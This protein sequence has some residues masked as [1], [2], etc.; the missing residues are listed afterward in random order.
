MYLVTT[1]DDKCAQIIYSNGNGWDWPVNIKLLHA[2]IDKSKYIDDVDRLDN[3]AKYILRNLSLHRPLNKSEF[4]TRS[5]LLKRLVE[6]GLP[7]VTINVSVNAIQNLCQNNDIN[8]LKLL[9][10]LP[11]KDIQQSSAVFQFAC[12]KFQFDIH[13]NGLHVPRGQTFHNLEMLES[14]D[15]FQDFFVANSPLSK[16]CY[17][18]RGMKTLDLKLEL[19]T[20]TF[21]TWNLNKALKYA[22]TPPPPFTVWLPSVLLVIKLH[23]NCPIITTRFPEEIVLPRY[24]DIHITNSCILTDVEISH[25]GYSTKINTLFVYFVDCLSSK[26]TRRTQLARQAV[27]F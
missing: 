9:P 13:D 11:D 12:E 21:A 5:D 27:S 3:I 15:K 26:R 8:N 14:L 6:L 17:V 19:N 20:V 7:F 4:N 18:F 22:Q 2:L 25:T 24:S 16:D 1:T 23:K 10:Q